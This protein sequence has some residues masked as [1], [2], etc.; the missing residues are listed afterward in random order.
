MFWSS[1]FYTADDR[2]LLYYD[3]ILIDGQLENLEVDGGIML[4][5]ISGY[6]YLDWIQ[7]CHDRIYWGAG[8]FPVKRNAWNVL[9]CW[10]IINKQNKQTPWPQSASELYHPND[11]RLSAKLVPTFAHRGCCV[12][13]KTDPYGRIF[14]FLDRSRYF[15]FQLAPQLYSRG[16]VN[17]VPDPLPLKNLVA[18]GIVPGPLDL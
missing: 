6:R 3:R 18:P 17:P 5:W 7:L 12:V 15:F 13:S 11:C 1:R 9:T 8:N 14:G 16:R 2:L 4:K 10:V